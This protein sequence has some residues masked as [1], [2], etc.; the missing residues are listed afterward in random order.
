MFRR[1]DLQRGHIVVHQREFDFGCVGARNAMFA[2][3]RRTRLGLL[4]IL[5]IGPPGGICIARCGGGL[6]TSHLGGHI[7]G[8]LRRRQFCKIDDEGLPLGRLGVAAPEHQQTA[9]R[10]FHAARIIVAVRL[11]RFARRIADQR[12]RLAHLGGRQEEMIGLFRLLRRR[13]RGCQLQVQ[14][15]IIAATAHQSA[16]TAAH[17]GA[18]AH[19]GHGRHIHAILRLG[20]CCFLGRAGDR[21]QNGGNRRQ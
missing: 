14:H 9:L 1:I 3:Q 10:L 4:A 21:C 12:H 8:H 13:R 17:H 15:I 19:A 16:K 2:T 18:H 7:C 6:H 20:T 11:R 5:P